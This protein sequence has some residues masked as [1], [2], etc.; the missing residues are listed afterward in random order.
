[1]KIIML[2]ITLFLYACGQNPSVVVEKETV[3]KTLPE[4]NTPYTP[5]ELIDPCGDTLN[6]V[7]EV[8][9]RLSNNQLLVLFA[10]N[11]NGDNPRLAIIG[12]GS[13]MTS[14]GSNCHFTVDNDLK[15][16]W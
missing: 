15:V 13:Y 6:I 10:D 9:V 16:I 11:V 1:M 14:D 4:V 5:S 7:D 2:T 8:L 3:T 12:P